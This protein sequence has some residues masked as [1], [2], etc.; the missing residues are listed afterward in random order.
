[1]LEKKEYMVFMSNCIDYYFIDFIPKT[2]RRY[3]YAV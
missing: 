1:M 2:A 3:P